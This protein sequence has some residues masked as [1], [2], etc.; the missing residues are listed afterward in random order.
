MKKDYTGR[1]FGRLIAVEYDKSVKG[2]SYWMCKC[3]CG[4]MKSIAL[5]SLTSGKTLS[6]GC[7]RNERVAAKCTTHGMS[8]TRLHK[9]W[10]GIKY[11][12]LNPNSTRYRYY[13]GRGIMICDEWKESFVSFMEWSN[14]NGYDDSL[15]IDRID[16]NGN[17]EPNNCR[18]TTQ[19]QQGHNRNLF[20]NNK[21][22]YSGVCWAK[23]RNK[24]RVTIINNGERINIGSFV[25]KDDAIKARKQ[26][27]EH[28]WGVI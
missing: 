25:N 9:E 28:Y 27:E 4:E 22:G 10:R 15:T 5:N 3:E 2:K 18:W 17:Y 19:L 20:S 16:N 8:K 7:L 13:G 23:D 14:K 11:R 21:S 1:T 24:W 26:A 12:C 6:C